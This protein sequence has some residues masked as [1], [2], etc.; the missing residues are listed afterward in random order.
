M[1]KKRFDAPKGGFTLIELLVIFGIV[2]LLLSAAIP[3]FTQF[4]RTFSSGEQVNEAARQATLLVEHLR[5][6]LHNA[7]PPSDLTKQSFRQVIRC[8]PSSLEFPVFADGAGNA[9]LVRYEILGKN[10]KRTFTGEQPRMLVTD[11]LASLTWTLFQDGDHPVSGFQA[12]RIWVHVEGMFGRA[13]Q[14]GRVIGSV[15]VSTNLFPVRWN[16]MVQGHP[17]N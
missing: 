13:D 1:Q 14:Q 7:A 5:N 15:P 10:V 6:D 4:R 3:A 17:Q 2:V 12:G 9:G 11:S 8:T 16:R